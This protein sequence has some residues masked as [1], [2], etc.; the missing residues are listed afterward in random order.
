MG[1]AACNE[2]CGLN[3]RRKNP[4]IDSCYMAWDS[5]EG[6]A[7]VW[8]TLILTSLHP[9]VAPSSVELRLVSM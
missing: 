1:W 2:A 5:L 8:I 7:G 9:W 6:F 4:R 3:V